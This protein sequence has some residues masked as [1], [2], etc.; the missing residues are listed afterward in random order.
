MWQY[1]GRWPLGPAKL[2]AGQDRAVV[3]VLAF[4]NRTKVGIAQGAAERLRAICWE[5][6]KL[7]SEEPI[8]VAVTLPTPWA[9]QIERA[10]LEQHRATRLEGEYFAADFPTICAAVETA[11]SQRTALLNTTAHWIGKVS[12]EPRMYQT[13]RADVPFQVVWTRTDQPARGGRKPRVQKCF[14]SEAE[15]TDFL[16]QAREYWRA[17]LLEKQIDAQ[18]AIEMLAGTS[19]TLT[20]LARNYLNGRR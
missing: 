10:V 17:G 7:A 14:A 12:G 4:R 19:I 13:T 11:W 16:N 5:H 8:S 9:R 15:A 2:E 1:S 3:Y 20:E 18:T 6:H